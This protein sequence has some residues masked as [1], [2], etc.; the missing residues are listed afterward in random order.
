MI[1]ILEIDRNNFEVEINSKDKT[2]HK[3]YFSDDF[4]KK[5]DKKFKSKKDIVFKSFQFLLKREKN[6][7]ILKTFNIQV[8]KN[9]FPEY[10]IFFLKDN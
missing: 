4:F 10:E 3:V 6:T 2:I 5:Y 7:S 1:N 8:I 9:Y